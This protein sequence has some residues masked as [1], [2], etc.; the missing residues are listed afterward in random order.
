[1]DNKPV[2]VAVDYA[3][4]VPFDVE[5][6]GLLKIPFHAWKVSG[7]FNLA[8]VALSRSANASDGNVQRGGRMSV[9]TKTTTV[10]DGVVAR[11]R[12]FLLAAE[13]GEDEDQTTSTEEKV[14]SAKIFE[15]ILKRFLR[16]FST[17]SNANIVDKLWAVLARTVT[18]EA[19]FNHVSR[20]MQSH[21][22]SCSL[23]SSLSLASDY[24]NF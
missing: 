23:W 9:D 18:S 8:D 21:H 19:T 12:R 15:S 17:P 11:R 3:C 2:T 16:T 22:F 14:P 24:F 6:C 13:A 5:L 1:M 7:D 20:Q 4:K 10:Y